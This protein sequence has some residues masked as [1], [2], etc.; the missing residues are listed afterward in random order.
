MPLLAAL[1]AP[2][3]SAAVQ[4]ADATPSPVIAQQG[5]ADGEIGYVLVD[6][7]NG[8]TVADW[9]GDRLFVPGSVL[10]LV[11]SLTAWKIL[12]EDF[13][14]TTR[15]WQSGDALYLQGSGD[16]VLTASDLQSLLRSL[17]ATRPGLSWRH[18]YLDASALHPAAMISD[19]QPLAADYNPG[20][21]ALNVDFNRLAVTPSRT[22]SD[23]AWQ[24]SSQA[25][26]LTVPVDWVPITPAPALLPLGAPF[27]PAAGD[28]D[29]PQDRWWYASDSLPADKTAAGEL[30][31]PV[32]QADPM[33]GKIFRAIAKG[34][35]IALPEPQ[36]GAVPTDA[37]L[38]AQHDSPALPGVLQGLLRYSNNLSAELIGMTAAKHLTGQA[39][40]LAAAAGAQRRWLTTNLPAVSWQG[41]RMVNHSGL[42]GDNRASPRQMAGLLQA[43]AA[44]PAL[45]DCLP[46]ITANVT[47][48]GAAAVPAG[49]HITGKSGTMD[50]AAGLAGLMTMPDHRQYAYVI[51]MADDRQRA[52]LDARFDARILQPAKDG[53]AWTL[54]ARQ[55]Q[56]G[57]LKA[58]VAEA[59][60][61]Q[62]GLQ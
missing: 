6:L 30:F 60:Q 41:F 38:L 10:K 33:T 19:R 13:R 61:Y 58:F 53:R 23:G 34:M 49:L 15:L 37:V 3:L 51:F 43:V 35:G 31:L 2:I 50:Y 32:K 48:G 29:K 57:L 7:A 8:K 62:A 54:R 21:G 40:S 4:A 25:Y 27:V 18:F 44:N 11:T 5:F 1:A 42:D 46:D 52:A 36:Y 17:Q 45:A 9:Q 55:L 39:G 22:R 47:E 12:G 16:P 14:F 26:G 20:F 28:G 59:E 56:T 24:V